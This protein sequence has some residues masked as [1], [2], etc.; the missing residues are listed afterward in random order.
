M[1]QF[2]LGDSIPS[3]TTHVSRMAVSVSLPTWKA[4]VGYEEGEQW[5]VGK[6]STGYPRFFVHKSIVAFGEDILA[7]HGRPHQRVMLFP[8]KR[9][10]QRCLDFVY[11][12]APKPVQADLELV[13][14][15]LKPFARTTETTQQITPAI[16]AVLCTVDAYPYLKQY[17]QRSGDGIS[18]RRAEFCHSLFRDGLLIR[19]QMPQS[20]HPQ[21]Q[22]KP[23]RGPRRYQRLSSIGTTNS[24]ATSP[25]Q[26]NNGFGDEKTED[27]ESS[28]FLEERY[29]RNLDVSLVDN[30]KAAIRR[31]IAQSFFKENDI[32]S[33]HLPAQDTNTRWVPNFKED[34]IYLLP[35]GMSA[36]FTAHQTL[37]KSSTPRKSISFGF[38]YADTLKILQIFGPGCIFYGNG[39]DG[40]LDDLELRLK[41]GERFQALF[42]EFP[43]NPLLKSPD[44]VRI[45]K[46]ADTYD[47]AVVVDETVGTF[48]NINV[49]PFAD[50]V[51]SSLTKIFSGD[52]NV[53]GGSLVLN[54][55]SRYYSALK[56]TLHREFEDTYWP[57]DVIF[58]ERNSRDFRSRI[59]R[60][61]ANSEVIVDML[62]AHPNVDNVFYPKYNKTRAYY[63]TCKRPH[64][65]YGGLLSCTFKQKAQAVVFYDSLETAKGPSLGTNF[66]LT[67]PYVI[68][69]HYMELHWAAGFGVNPNLLRIS[70]GLEE[71]EYLRSVFMKALEATEG[72]G[73]KAGS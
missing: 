48:V 2:E 71:T 54:P 39:A 61:N 46:M 11:E 6:L 20:P 4:I 24:V 58:M 70:V 68:L 63:E 59:D 9:I 64:G 21:P 57:E 18:S 66:T 31:R 73:S 35:C 47:F 38:P 19:E 10:A 72:V 28:R 51:V 14:L 41:V 42:C 13:H 22:G 44:L 23:F 45:R 30:A 25:A 34:D 60:V 29:G 69:A 53:M 50:I 5:V 15:I 55:N 43:S 17:W 26:G 36:I 65:G 7:S 12:Q 33:G 32:T 37:L 56:S 27:L 40:D 1:P 52:C 3:N 67:S 16:S 49:L 8:T 62:R